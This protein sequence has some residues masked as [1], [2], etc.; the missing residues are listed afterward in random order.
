MLAHLK[1]LV[2][3]AKRN[4]YALGA[5]NTINLETTLAIVHAARQVKIPAIIQIS[6]KTIA[7][8]GL[9][10]IL[11]LIK[12][13]VQTESAQVPI[14][15]HLDHGRNFQLIKECIAAGISSVQIDASDQPF[16]KNIKLTGQVAA[17]AHQRGVWVQGEL[18]SLLGQEG[19]VKG[20]LAA[21]DDD[22]T[23][24][25]QVKEFVKKTNVDTLAVSVGTMH[26]SFIGRENINL[27]LISAI[28][29][30]T[31]KPLVL[32]GSSGNRNQKI[33]AA[34]RRGI[35]IINV[36]TDLRLAFI[37]SLRQTLK[38]QPDFY[39]PRQILSPSI[40]AMQRA[41][42]EKIQTFRV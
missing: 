2:K 17:Y 37:K 26:G 16:K 18:G 28:A 41:V 1:D 32:H 22:L 39:D 6:E 29:E 23:D 20:K 24:P 3:L 35:R 19:T 38:A 21:A 8:A 12:S 9:Q 7:Y 10:T 40:L 42:A 13:V 34:I 27:A 36:D 14:A 11:K 15:I 30:Q 33:V 25:G 5:F 4:G 31:A